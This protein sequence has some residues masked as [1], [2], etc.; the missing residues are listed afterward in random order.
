MEVHVAVRGYL[1]FAFIVVLVAADAHAQ[2]LATPPLS[3]NDV[4]WLFPPPKVA[5]DFGKLI[6]VRDLTAP[7]PQD[8][9]K[10][11]AVWP[12]A[13]FQQFLAIA[14]GSAAQVSGTQ[15]RIGLPPEAQSMAAWFIAGIR[16][17]AG[18]PGLADD[19]R[20]QYGQS[21]EIRLIVQLVT[22]NPD[23]TPNVHDI[24]G[25]LIFDF[26]TQ[27]PD[28]P[29]AAGCFPRPVPDLVALKEIVADIAAL[30]TRLSN[31]Q[32]GANKIVTA[33]VPLGIHPGLAD[34]TTANGVRQEMI[35]FLERHISG[36]RLNSMAI[37][38]LPVGAP[39]PWI[40]LALEKL[41]PGA[42]P[43][44]PNGGFVPVPGP[45]LDGQQFAQMLVPG[46]ASFHVIPE[47]HTNNL[48]KIT[49]KNAAIPGGDALPVAKRS[50]S[51]TSELFASQ[52][53]SPDNV[54][55]ILDLI[56]DPTRSHFFNTDCISCHTETR[57]AK[58]LL[59]DVS[60][61]NPAVVPNTDWN[62]RNFGWSPPGEGPLQ[63]TVT[64]RTAAETAAVVA[65]INSQ[66]LNK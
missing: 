29:A 66:I 15:S 45:A 21:P 41:P 61:I 34:K 18:A 38:G 26:V 46:G 27:Q 2:P 36:D 43:A 49:C 24:A 14:A 5:E 51:S 4:S 50:G 7:N 32:L 13:A 6:P 37:M 35:S 60:G 16:I 3:A 10:R 48:N 20:A 23:G 54:R 12:D 56:V 30:R 11:D 19:I 44:L 22:R 64:R 47:P 59:P 62:V 42:L 57:R 65:F 8:P 58:S 63:G 53:G 33:G 55:K 31:G 17:D 39:A 28:G 9:T 25:H 52:P 40:F 1:K